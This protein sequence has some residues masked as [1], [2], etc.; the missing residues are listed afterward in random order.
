LTINVRVQTLKFMLDHSRVDAVFHALAEPT[1]RAIFEQL[2][3]GPR[4]VSD[5]AAPF[6]MTLAAVVQH[7]QVLERSGLVRSEK[8]GR[9]RTCRVEPGG[10]GV[11]ERWVA[12]HRALW[13]RRLDRLGD[14]LDEDA[15]AATVP[16]DEKTKKK[17][18]KKK[19]K[20]RA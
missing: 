16:K 11:L 2:A 15:G 7:V 19:R 3:E 1:R 12:D 20:K 8:L 5:L 14:I 13:A 9:V 10:L 17:K 4:S 18:S 6:S